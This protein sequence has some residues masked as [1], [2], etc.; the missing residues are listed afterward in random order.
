[1][2][3]DLEGEG[4]GH[5]RLRSLFLFGFLV[6]VIRSLMCVFL[7]PLH[8]CERRSWWRG[9]EREGGW[10]SPRAGRSPFQSAID[11]NAYCAS[12]IEGMLAWKSVKTASCCLTWIPCFE[13]DRLLCGMCRVWPIQKRKDV[14]WLGI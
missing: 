10:Y 4:A 9:R 13:D 7:V 3:Q 8:S 2:D 1:M 5:Q 11:F 6:G 12:F 14:K